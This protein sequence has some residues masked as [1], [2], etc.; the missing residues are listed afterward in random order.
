[1]R[2][3]ISSK[4]NHIRQNL[5]DRYKSGFP[6][7]KELIQNADDAYASK[8]DLVFSQGIPDAVNPLLRGPA[9]VIVND[10]TFD[11][12]N[13][14]AM[15]SISLSSKIG[16]SN[17]VGRYGLGLK[18]VFHLCEAFFFLSSI[19]KSLHIVN[20]YAE[21]VGRD[22][23]ED[24]TYP[25]WN[26]INNLEYTAVI[27]AIQP[28]IKDCEKYLCIWIPLRKKEH[29]NLR[30]PIMPELPGE[31]TANFEDMIKPNDNQSLGLNNEM[32]RL[33]PQLRKLKSI[34]FS[35]LSNEKPL[36]VMFEIKLDENADRMAFPLRSEEITPNKHRDFHGK[37]I[38]DKDGKQREF[39][40]AGVEKL[41]KEEIFDELTNSNYWPTQ[42]NQ[43]PSTGELIDLRD[44][45]RPHIGAVFTRFSKNSAGGKL[46][47]S[48]AVFLPLENQFELI[49]SAGHF[50]V[51]LTLHGWY[52]VDAG[53]KELA[54]WNKDYQEPLENSSDLL[55]HWNAALAQKGTLQ[56]IIPALEHFIFT[57][58]LS[59]NE[60]ESISAALKGSHLFSE[61]REDICKKDQWVFSYHPVNGKW[62]RLSV[63]QKILTL[64]R[65]PALD[66]DRPNK[67]FP[68]IF[69]D[70][71][72]RFDGK[73]ITIEGS[74]NLLLNED[75]GFWTT[76]D[77]IHFLSVIPV[78]EVFA[79]RG[80]LVYLENFLKK[81]LR[82]PSLQP[83]SE[84]TAFTSVLLK[85]AR[86]AFATIE[87]SVL[88]NNR[89]AIKNICGILPP[90]LRFPIRINEETSDSNAV[91]AD[92]FK[93][94]IDLL[95]IP[96][97][98]DLQSSNAKPGL[99]LEKAELILQ[100]LSKKQEVAT[101][102]IRSRIAMQVVSGCEYP[103]RLKDA[104]GNLRLF[105]GKKF[106]R[107]TSQ[108]ALFALNDLRELHLFK[109][110][111]NA[112]ELLRDLSLAL[113][114]DSL[115]G[116]QEYI[117]EGLNLNGLDTMAMGSLNLLESMPLLSN[118]ANR[119]PLLRYL[120]EEMGHSQNSSETTRSVKAIRYLLHGQKD[121]YSSVVV[122]LYL[123][124]D[125][126]MIS[127]LL[128]KKALQV[129]M[130]NWRVIDPLMADLFTA[131][132]L[133]KLGVSL[134]TENSTLLLLDELTENQCKNLGFSELLEPER[135][136]IILSL[137]QEQ[138]FDLLRNLKLHRTNTG[139]MVYLNNKTFMESKV[140]LPSGFEEDA[141]LL[142]VPD[143]GMLQSVYET[144]HVIPLDSVEIINLAVSKEN[145][146]EYWQTI[147]D[148]FDSLRTVPLNTI[149]LLRKKEWLPVSD[150]HV[151]SPQKVLHLDGLESEISG[152]LSE[153]D[154]VF[155]GTRSIAQ[156]VI[157][158]KS[159]KALAKKVLP[160]S[161]EVVNDLGDLINSQDK[162]RI[163]NFD[164][165]NLN[166][167][168][169]KTFE[170][171][172]K[173]DKGCVLMPV[174]PVIQKIK[175]Q[176]DVTLAIN[177]IKLL[178]GQITAHRLTEILN[179]LSVV[180]EAA[181]EDRKKSVSTIFEQFID[182]FAL[183]TEYRD[184]ILPEIRLLSE[185]K[186]WKPAKQLAY[187]A[188]G[189]SSQD[190][191][192]NRQGER[193]RLKPSNQSIQEDSLQNQV[194]PSTYE[195]DLNTG[196]QKLLTYFE[197]WEPYIENQELLGGVLCLFGGQSKIKKKA[198]EYLGIRDVD[199]TINILN[200]QPDAATF[201]Q[202]EL[203]TDR[204]KRQY[205]FI[206]IVD[207]KARKVP[208]QSIIGT[209]FDADLLKA[210]ELKHLLYD[211]SAYKHMLPKIGRDGKVYDLLCLRKID[212]EQ[213]DAEQMITLLKNTTK[214]ILFELYYQEP[215]N[216]NDF[217]QDLEHTDQLSLEIAQDMII[218][219]I[220]SYIPMLGLNRD[221]KFMSMML[222]WDKTIARETQLR[223]NAKKRGVEIDKGVEE[224][225]NALR[226]EM[227]SILE[228]IDAH[229]GRE[230]EVLLD[231]IRIK[232]G[233]HY[234]YKRSSVLFELFQNAD[235]AVAELGLLHADKRSRSGEYVENFGSDLS[236][237][238]KR[239]VV[240]WGS[241][242]LRFAHWGRTINQIRPG[243][244]EDLGYSND[245]VK[246]LTMQR[247]DKLISPDF[248]AKPLTGK[249]GLGFK[250][251][252]LVS[253]APTLLSG[254][255][256][257]EISAGVY[258]RHPNPDNYRRLS[259]LLEDWNTANEVDGT[260]ID[261][262]LD[263]QGIQELY[264]ESVI[265]DF[266]KWANLL[267]VFSNQIN[268][269]EL[270]RDGDLLN[271]CEWKPEQLPALK[272]WST[273]EIRS[274]YADDN[275]H[276][277]RALVWKTSSVFDHHKILLQDA[278]GSVLFLVGPKGCIPLPAELPNLWVTAPT[279]EKFPSAFV[280]NSNFALDVGRAQLAR[281][282]EGNSL[283]AIE[284]GRK[285]GV[286]LIEL[287]NFSMSNWA[288]LCTL[289]GL[290]PGISNYDFWDSIWTTSC[291]SMKKADAR[292]SHQLIRNF[293]G[294]KECGF[295]HLYQNVKAL[296]TG[297][298]G[299]YRVLTKLPDI[300]YYI[301]GALEESR[302]FEQ[303]STWPKI[304]EKIPVGSAVSN[305][306]RAILSILNPDHVD[307]TEIKLWRV[308]EWA[309][310]S[311]GQVT[312]KKAGFMGKLIVP[313]FMSDLDRNEA[314]VLRQFMKQ[315][316]FLNKSGEYTDV[317][318]L[319]SGNSENKSD[320]VDEERRS[321]F[322]PDRFVLS[323]EYS[324]DGTQFFRA[325]REKLS[326][327]AEKLASW[328]I[329]A[330][331]QT[332][333]QGVLD[334]LLS[335]ELD[336]A[337]AQILL[338]V[339]QHEFES[340]WLSGLYDQHELLEDFDQDDR[341]II[342]GRL[343]LSARDVA[344]PPNPPGVSVKSVLELVYLWWQANRS[345]LIHEF[346][347]NLYPEG[348]MTALMSEEMLFNSDE[349]RQSWM[350][351]FLL[352]SFHTIGRVGTAAYRNFIEDC[353][354]KEWMATFINM[355][356]SSDDWINVLESYVETIREDNDANYQ[357][358]FM[359][360][361]VTIYTLS[362]HLPQYMEVFQGVD[363][364]NRRFSI[365]QIIDPNRSEIYSGSGYPAIPSLS[366]T[367]GIGTGFVMREL[368]R[369]KVINSPFA[370]E[371]C[372]SPVARVRKLF[373]ELGLELDGIPHPDQSVKIYN[374]LTSELGEEQA[375]FENSFDIPFLIIAKK[376]GS[377]QGF[378]NQH[379]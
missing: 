295:F 73:T 316:K 30:T 62:V 306:N 247:S 377:L 272:E 365:D 19:D 290:E 360:Q 275:L 296:P 243:N 203:A 193:L 371:H 176:Y 9:L 285:F 361:F 187:K 110:A 211:S 20:P 115:F 88:D 183:Q 106:F 238:N 314:E 123:Q 82:D 111:R 355:N 133:Q 357:Y 11:E 315:L 266:Y 121:K 77:L 138:K 92:L 98:F 40:Y 276:S 224:K 47:I 356:A 255:I 305:S 163:G 223:R 269:I 179:Y 125:D 145:A 120:I 330:E 126:G 219:N 248:S 286:A 375:T 260:L 52:F 14:L 94:K 237:H 326:A 353:M 141:I 345:N 287:F 156:E 160:D 42:S 65:P 262:P 201:H 199:E 100:F 109:L 363:R 313:S 83:R 119:L 244:G 59:Q 325:C 135:I 185:A 165:S 104:C 204:V 234:Q 129:K 113:S 186:K 10:G 192:D 240:D 261:L 99:E 189:I 292:E 340:S 249:F 169:L 23:E 39:E 80:M 277:A 278:Q 17:A 216:F 368:V 350:I 150:G 118:P 3:T 333:R 159:W 175:D 56:A 51:G 85:I 242:Y 44:N 172:F 308:V 343:K 311:S 362:R 335:G 21:V 259:N 264:V 22:L 348:G 331:S 144:L 152:L 324:S 191:L 208:V 112:D 302:V 27:N 26:V 236:D 164:S 32:G 153:F 351:L 317:A 184:V 174:F 274:M 116:I 38:L 48:R 336:S 210:N 178:C 43:N 231:A 45:A 18:S 195:N 177:F 143:N 332:A 70:F 181:P 25:A 256:K 258:P 366:K 167:N 263:I 338:T 76:Q 33:F 367:L 354:K 1:M 91:L 288:E 29:F 194:D 215:N 220:F 312:A 61:Y 370:F 268:R 171:S 267:A 344:I 282:S 225:K 66:L 54:G 253:K 58:K 57:T 84:T 55:I 64:P 339:R 265:H 90:Q 2:D 250:S 334:Y 105:K 182:S 72:K 36:E 378:W 246:M 89:E 369:Q 341:N 50:E 114:D 188:V 221:E 213:T 151:I 200:W 289:M 217:W 284:L 170:F 372:Y 75:E 122:I 222:E 320:Y 214:E 212:L 228:S 230:R 134:L 364:I 206:K 198:K 197:E 318:N 8:I 127:S 49:S 373:N 146:Y 5:K 245:L 74:P 209:E 346:E 34:R 349:R 68:G 139:A 12:N 162:Y 71:S 227:R 137:C 196:A 270:R 298:H 4:I 374:F 67:I 136:K 78:Q 16:N 322:A 329:A 205:L 148:A 251:V 281:A 107:G 24:T 257:F 166:E 300:H 207:Q 161:E 63:D 310:G 41:L 280:L 303:V 252:Y 299:D 101:E 131:N 376:Y 271:S 297:L 327:S 233:D 69:D 190:L 254:N 7:L 301:S 168:F 46:G 15:N 102:E 60:I 239:V 154:S 81:T 358:L 97:R 53:R 218:E 103:D 342:L 173:D 117:I 149:D 124:R 328:A 307:L 31:V 157:Q 241:D 279:E 128:A 155:I 37:L 180:H 273:G 142:K 291:V 108:S 6:I 321:R 304:G 87:V 132:L 293:L 95:I 147:L 235:D 337:L 309:V 140:A 294:E 347:T 93:L 79:N 359:R 283:R 229:G 86:E 202:R 28:V 323:D 96:D 130:E 319:V 379:G 352:G 158:H 35:R 232:I 226:E 13:A